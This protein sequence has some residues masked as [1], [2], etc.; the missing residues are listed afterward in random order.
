MKRKETT[1]LKRKEETNWKRKPQIFPKQRVENLLASEELPEM[2][3]SN[4]SRDPL[5][6]TLESVDK[7]PTEPETEHN[8]DD[9]IQAV[10]KTDEPTEAD[11]P[12]R[13]SVRHPE[14]TRRFHYPEFGNPLVSVVSRVE[15]RLD[16]L[17]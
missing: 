10:E 2:E 6:I 12:L 3:I 8:T 7:Y 1:N 5:D 9:Y 16:Q 11:A 13:R 15:H 14:P 17:S 4:L